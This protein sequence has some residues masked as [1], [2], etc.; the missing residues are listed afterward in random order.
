MR[1]TVKKGKYGYLQGT[2][3]KCGETE[4]P[5]IRVTDDSGNKNVVCDTCANTIRR[6]KQTIDKLKRV[7]KDKDFLDRVMNG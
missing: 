2:C 6:V 3:N 5:L 4:L 7:E 1:I